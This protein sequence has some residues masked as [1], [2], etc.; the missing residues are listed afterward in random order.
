MPLNVSLALGLRRNKQRA[1]MSQL[2]KFRLKI[3]SFLAVEVD[4]ADGPGGRVMR[5]SAFAGA[6]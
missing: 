6:I 1:L 5:D 2:A 4:G 3:S